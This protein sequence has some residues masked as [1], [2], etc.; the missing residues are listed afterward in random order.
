MV[1]EKDEGAWTR[2]ETAEMGRRVWRE[3]LAGPAD[4]LAVGP[5]EG[6]NEG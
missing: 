5:E 4:T 6:R 3:E 1:R 2:T